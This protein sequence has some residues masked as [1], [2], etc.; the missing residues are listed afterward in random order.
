MLIIPAIDILGGKVVRLV[1]GIEEKAK[2]YSNDPLK[3]ASRFEELGAR[4]IHVVDLDGA[5]NRPEVNDSVIKL[6]IKN[7]SIPI[8][9]GGGIRSL[10][11]I[12]Y[13]LDMGVRR[14]VLGSMIV[15]N[16]NLV[17]K[18]GSQ[19]GTEPLVAG[20]DVKNGYVSIHG[21]KSKSR[22]KPLDLAREMKSV[23]LKRVIVTE[24]A[25]DGM[26]VGP[27]LEH[28]TVIAKSTDLSV[29][30]SGGVGSLK[31]I[32][33]VAESRCFEGV[34]VGKALYETKI[35]LNEAIENYQN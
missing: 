26:L 28:A 2:V 14:V 27:K 21:W 31:D 6:L 30:V 9:L 16:P 12:K 19:Y 20:I 3:M 32:E 33:S 24:I 29:I 15:E 8:E 13:W 22:V 18:A 11:R 1:Q 25:A 10:D 7:L 5:F 34:I 23:G 4:F 17:E 35:S